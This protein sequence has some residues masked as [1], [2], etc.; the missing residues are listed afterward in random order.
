M[1]PGTDSLTARRSEIRIPIANDER[2]IADAL[3]V[4]I[5]QRGF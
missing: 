2:A 4:I 3:Q 5:C 1:Q